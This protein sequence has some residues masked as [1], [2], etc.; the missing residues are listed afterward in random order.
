LGTSHWVVCWSQGHMALD[1]KPSAPWW[2]DKDLSGLFLY[3]YDNILCLVGSAFIPCLVA[4]YLI[5]NVQFEHIALG[6]S[7]RD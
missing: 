2:V 5:S 3:H 4:K 7:R 6:V 1:T